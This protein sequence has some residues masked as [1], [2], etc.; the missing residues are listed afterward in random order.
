MPNHVPKAFPPPTLYLRSVPERRPHQPEAPYA[1]LLVGVGTTAWGAR[2]SRAQSGGNLPVHVCRL[3]FCYLI[4]QL[5]FMAHA[6]RR[7][8]PNYSP[9]ASF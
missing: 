7:P 8:V 6:D 5:S 9:F 1:L 3:D 4:Q 2:T